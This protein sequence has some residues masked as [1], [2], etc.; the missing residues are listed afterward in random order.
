MVVSVRN[1]IL[2]AGIILLF[3]IFCGILY[4]FSLFITADVLFPGKLNVKPQYWWFLYKETPVTPG[5]LLNS[6]IIIL[7]F[8]LFCFIAG[9]LF[10]RLFIKIASPEIFFYTIFLFCFSFEGFRVFLLYIQLGMPVFLGLLFTR[11]V[12]FGRFFG[13]IAFFLS[14]LYSLEIKYQNFGILLGGGLALSL[15]AAYIVPLDSSIILSQLIYKP[16][17][18]L[19]IFLANVALGFFAII[20]FLI[21]A[22]L[23][24]KRFLYVTLTS[25]F[26]F[27]GR[28]LF[29]FIT[30]PVTGAAGICLLIT[31][32]YFFYRQIDKIYLWY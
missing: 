2:L 9:I 16:G 1:N 28:E 13:L 3:L 29:L 22:F 24:N 18:E 23:R 19:S 11:I 5:F 15:I 21:A 7:I 27:G 32:T 30:G 17:D 8:I 10:R 14:S 12:I 26:I 4:S 25:L 6:I 31:G 20:N